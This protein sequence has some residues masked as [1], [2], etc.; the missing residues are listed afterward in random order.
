MSAALLFLK[1][2]IIHLSGTTEEE[3]FEER[4]KLTDLNP[5]AMGATV[6]PQTGKN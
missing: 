1:K 5:G 6:T 4:R 3:E 2:F